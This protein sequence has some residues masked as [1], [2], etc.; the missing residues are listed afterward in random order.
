[1][2]TKLLER[3]PNPDDEEIRDYLCGNLCRCAAYPEIL[4]A[5]KVAATELA[6]THAQ[7]AGARATD[8]R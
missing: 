2:S 5:V 8:V 4:Q 6:S 3:N 1:M 7:T